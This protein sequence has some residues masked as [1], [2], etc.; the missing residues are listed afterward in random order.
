[1]LKDVRRV[2]SLRLRD[3]VNRH[4]RTALGLTYRLAVTPPVREPHRAQHLDQRKSRGH[5]ILTPPLEPLK[6]SGAVYEATTVVDCVP[7]ED[8]ASLLRREPPGVAIL[9][10]QVG[11]APSKDL[12]PESLLRQE[13]GAVVVN[14]PGVAEDLVIPVTE[15]EITDHL[16]RLTG[17]TRKTVPVVGDMRNLRIFL[18]V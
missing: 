16:L 4:P 7:P 13:P 15:L 2:A 9:V 5:G 17:R 6:D 3:G 11:R 10:L 14:F 12:P 8:E 1:P 18:G